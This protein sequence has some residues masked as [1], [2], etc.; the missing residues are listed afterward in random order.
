MENIYYEL[1]NYLQSLP[2]GYPSTEEKIEL[3]ILK[4]LFTRED[5]D[6]FVK[7]SKNVNIFK[8]YV[9]GKEKKLQKAVNMT[10][11]DIPGVLTMYEEHIKAGHY[12]KK[13]LL[14]VSLAKSFITASNFIQKVNSS[15][16]QT[17]S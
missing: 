7:I 1:R 12:P 15:L 16:P 6:I 11:S 13:D 3:K 17:K 5:A 9:S 10:E 8:H 4:K 14:K 2:L